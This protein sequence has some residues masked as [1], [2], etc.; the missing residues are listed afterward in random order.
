[1]AVDIGGQRWPTGGRVSTRRP[2]GAAVRLAYEAD[3]S[4]WP[5]L[6][7]VLE[8]DASATALRAR[9]DR[10]ARPLWRGG[11]L[12]VPVVPLDAAL[13]AVLAS[14][15]RTGTLVLGLEAAAA[16]LDREEHGLAAL[17][18]RG[19][20]TRASR[21]S[22][23]LILADDGAERFYRAAEQM[24]RRHAGRLLTCRL[25][26]PAPALGRAVLGREAG[27]KAVLVRHKDAVVGALR[28]IGAARERA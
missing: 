14:A 1:M 28:A 2:F 10:A 20:A 7:R 6:P 15:A 9:I 26:A 8:A 19:S 21:I 25:E 11:T 22:R 18:A 5:P 12:L 16:A 23:L 3:V 24:T 4:S 17:A 13:A 27:L